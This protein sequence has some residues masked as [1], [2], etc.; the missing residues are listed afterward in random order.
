MNQI[1][2]KFEDGK[3]RSFNSGITLD[4][5]LK[6]T[7]P[8]KRDAL[9]A[10]VDG[11]ILDLSRVVDSAQEI[12]FLTANDSEGLQVLWHSSAHVM[13]QAVR[14]IFG[15]VALGVG[16]A[17]SNGFYYDF[18][19]SETLSSDLLERIESKMEEIV[20]SNQPFV[21]EVMSKKD[22]SVLFEARGERFK[23][24]LIEDIPDEEVSVYRN[25]DFVDL[26]RGPHVPSTG[27]VKNFKLLSVAGAY[28]R[29]DEH[30]AV[31][32][33]IY[34]ISFQDKKEL[35]K[36]LAMLEEAKK[37]D[38]RRLAKELDLFS[39]QAEGPGFPFWHANG[40]IL[41]NEVASYM[42]N[43][44]DS[45]GYEEIKTPI[46]M[47]EALWHRSGH[48]DHYK[49]NMYFTQIDEQDY[50]VKPM[51]CPGALL[52]Y[53]NSPHSY[54]EF[55]L[56]LSE[57]GMV[58]RHEKS[59]VLHGLFRVRMFTQDDAHV[60]CTPEQM[61]DEVIKIIDLIDEVYQ[62]FGFEN[63]K[64][65]LSTRPE[66]SIGSAEMW[67]KAETAL[68]NALKTKGLDY[69]LNPG[70]G[71]FYGPKIDYHIQDSIG[72]TWQCGTIQLDFSM[73]ERFELEYVGADGSKHR[74]VMLHR[75][76]LGSI[77]RFIGILIEHYG[78][79][80][81]VWL[82]PVQ[83]T[84]IPVS[85]KH[86]DYAVKVQE[87]LKSI[88]I[89]VKLD[90]RSEKVGFKIRE[91]AMKKVPYMCIVG[92]AEIENETLAIRKRGTGDIGTLSLDE[93]S[94]IIKDEI[95]RRISH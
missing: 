76:I 75:A 58:H 87:V 47:N 25:G 42:R 81:P 55:P 16:P 30:N 65:E 93:F 51:N 41:Y 36:Y 72:R 29:G 86:L 66:K 67:E 77:E 60:F 27:F 8:N 95:T 71:A 68:R 5:I 83:T 19:L 39:F 59:G 1:E 80:F 56:K 49:E 22:A 7:Y 13:A 11:Q 94:A 73:P 85:E 15:D 35:K 88:G 31:L 84:I 14:A 50:A 4:E 54:K 3:K 44:L 89:R 64:M 37:R 70:D 46:I 24:E 20:T 52:I 61:E 33:R 63:Y 28:W 21:R 74:P 34:G 6:E 82:A 78:G 40:M 43:L 17:I 92:D 12:K 23:L 57:M 53:K 90:S 69:Q 79:A 45:R 18:A 38:H 26:C 62:T 91:A 9:A 32:Q 48:W 10:N 2:I